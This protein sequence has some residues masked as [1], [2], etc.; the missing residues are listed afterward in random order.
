MT[1]HGRGPRPAG[2]H[3]TDGHKRPLSAPYAT[4]RTLLRT[5]PS[6]P[7]AWTARNTGTAAPAG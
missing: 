1:R 7:K 3:L 6:M 2:G 4:A 5:L